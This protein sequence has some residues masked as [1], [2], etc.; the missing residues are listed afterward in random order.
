MLR[1][2]LQIVEE[3]FAVLDGASVNLVDTCLYSTVCALQ[4]GAVQC[5]SLCVPSFALAPIQGSV[6][7]F[8][9]LLLTKASGRQVL[10]GERTSFLG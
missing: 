7:C 9:A 2:P 10:P 6:Y 3:S 4:L 1:L 5:T 8:C